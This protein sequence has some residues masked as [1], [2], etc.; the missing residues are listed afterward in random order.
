MKGYEQ[1]TDLVL[2]VREFT[3]LLQRQGINLAKLEESTFD[4]P[5]MS[6]NTG[7]GVI[8]GATGGVM[9]AA[10]RTVYFKATG[11]GGPR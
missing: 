9:E 3:R 2:T 1:D 10:L 5:F 8:F 6:E 11:R 4:S 7:A